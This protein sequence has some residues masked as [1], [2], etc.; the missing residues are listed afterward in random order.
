MPLL[1]RLRS[2][3]RLTSHINYRG[4]IVLVSTSTTGATDEHHC[5]N[6]EG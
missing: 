2:R 5:P 6:P 3:G 1:R 4:I